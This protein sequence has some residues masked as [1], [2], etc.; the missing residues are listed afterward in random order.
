MRIALSAAPGASSHTAFFVDIIDIPARIEI[1][2]ILT[3]R[4]HG[5]Y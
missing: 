4:G 1:T 5:A 3:R 2:P